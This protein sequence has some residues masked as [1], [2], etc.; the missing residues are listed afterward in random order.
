MLGAGG[1]PGPN[2][3]PRHTVAGDFARLVLD[4]AHAFTVRGASASSRIDAYGL[5]D[6]EHLWSTAVRGMVIRMLAGQRAEDFTAKFPNIVI[7]NT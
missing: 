2:L 7:Q 3:D 5:D 1:P 4:D 6:G